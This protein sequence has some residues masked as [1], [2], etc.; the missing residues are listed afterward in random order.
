MVAH[1]LKR[2]V[3]TVNNSFKCIYYVV[4]WFVLMTTK[5][6]DEKPYDFSLTSLS[7]GLILLMIP[8]SAYIIGLF[9]VI[10]GF[11]YVYNKLLLL[12][13]GILFYFLLSIL[14]VVSFFIL[15][16][17]ESFIPLF[18]V[19]L[20]HIQVTPG[21]HRLTVKDKNFFYHMLFFT[22]YRPGLKLISSLP[23]VP[24]RTKL[25]KLAGLTIGKTSLLAGTEFIDEPYGVCI[26]EHTLIGGFSTIYAHISD[27]SLRLKPVKIGNNCF[28]GNKSV[29][30]PGV[31]IEDNV[32]LEPG[33][34]V[35][36]D[37]VLKK[38]KRYAGNPVQLINS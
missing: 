6:T 24:L 23:L 10:F 19:K 16:I 32:F 25:V 5:I 37:Q 26:G 31:T 18:F 1:Q 3:K 34:V 14:L 30:L 20:F 12:F 11:F 2:L 38:G 17:L 8:L 4:Y 15:V 29:I 7:R 22:L 33:S 27:T 36:E 21:E 28:I 35:R 9:P 13:Q